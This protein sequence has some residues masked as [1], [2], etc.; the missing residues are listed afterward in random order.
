MNKYTLELT[1]LEA[2]ALA[3]AGF[4]GLKGSKP[5]DC[6]DETRESLSA[7][8]GKILAAVIDIPS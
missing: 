2:R 5:I 1:P 8:L 7:K 3:V 4:A 6:A